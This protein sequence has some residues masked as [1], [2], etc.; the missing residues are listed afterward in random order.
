MAAV[1]RVA[2]SGQRPFMTLPP[3]R[4]A[5]APCGQ[6]LAKKRIKDSSV[7]TRKVETRPGS[8]ANRSGS[9]VILNSVEGSPS[10]LC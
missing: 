1:G 6:R 8:L 5:F 7:T 3:P 9:Q 4:G 2:D 10:A